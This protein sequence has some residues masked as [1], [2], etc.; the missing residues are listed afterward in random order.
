[1][2]K[3]VWTSFWNINIYKFITEYIK[4]RSTKKIDFHIFYLEVINFGIQPWTASEPTSQ[5]EVELPLK[6]KL[7]VTFHKKPL[8]MAHL[9][10]KA[11]YDFAIDTKLY[12]NLARGR[13]NLECSGCRRLSYQLCHF[14][15]KRATSP[16]SLSSFLTTNIIC[17]I[18]I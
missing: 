17:Y 11:F 4:V 7:C 9:A 8:T 12:F 16:T 14:L 13:V 1:M 5:I 6:Y 15:R 10:A 18:C 2:T 3:Q